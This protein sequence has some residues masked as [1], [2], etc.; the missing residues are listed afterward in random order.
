MQSQHQQ[1]Q[2]QHPYHDDEHTA[3]QNA[4]LRLTPG[5]VSF[6]ATH[7]RADTCHYAIATRG[8]KKWSPLDVLMYYSYTATTAATTATTT[9][10]HLAPPPLLP[11]LRAIE[12]YII[13]H[14]RTTP[15]FVVSPEAVRI[16]KYPCT[17]CLPPPP[18]D[19]A[20]P[21]AE[22]EPDQIVDDG[23]HC[24]NLYAQY[25]RQLRDYRKR[26]LDPF[27]RGERL[28]LEI[29]PSAAADRR[30]GE[31]DAPAMVLLLQTSVP[32][33]NFFR[34]IICS[35]VLQ[36]IVLA[37][38]T[39]ATAITDV[40]VVSKAPARV[41]KKISA[42]ATVDVDVTLTELTLRS[43]LAQDDALLPPSI[44]LPPFALIQQQLAI[45]IPP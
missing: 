11:S 34:W 15:M 40:T 28:P 29:P 1:H 4:V 22:P 14:C 10:P 12:Q 20:E 43:H 21:E 19:A 13:G 26:G 38:A 9:P 42:A 16:A 24:L 5:L 7:R 37:L 39:T 2:Q 41:S 27:R 36:E 32:Q 17:K 44:M 25:R 18:G 33:M 30:Q 8:G 45:T 35:G 6:F 31:Q 23:A 3:R